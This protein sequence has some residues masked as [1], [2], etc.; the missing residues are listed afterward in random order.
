MHGLIHVIFKGFVVDTFGQ[1]A[2]QEIMRKA[3][4]EDDSTILKMQQYDDSLTFAAIQIGSEVAGAPMDAA[5]ELF[6]AYFVQFAA[7]NGFLSLLKSLGSNLAEFLSNLNILHH[8]IERDFTSAVFPLFEVQAASLPSAKGDHTFILRYG[9][10][11]PG[12]FPL[13]RGALKKTADLLFDAELE[14][15]ELAPTAADPAAL[16]WA[17]TTTPTEAQV[18][19]EMELTVRPRSVAQQASSQEPPRN[20]HGTFYHSSAHL[21]TTTPTPTTT[22]PSQN[23][24][25]SNNNNNNNNNN[26][27]YSY[28]FFDLHSALASIWACNSAACKD[29][30]QSSTQLEVVEAEPDWFSR[31]SA[32]LEVVE[33]EPNWFSKVAASC[34]EK[35]AAVDKVCAAYQNLDDA[36]HP[37]FKLSAKDRVKVGVSL[38]RGVVAGQIAA[39]WTDQTELAQATEF[40]AAYEKLDSFYA[41]SRDWLQPGVVGTFPRKEGKIRFLSQSWG[42][43]MGWDEMMGPNSSYSQAKAAEICC[44]AKD[45]ASRELGDVSRWREVGFWLDKCCIPQGDKVLMSWCVNLLEEFIVFSDGLIVLVP[46][47]Y[48]TRL[49]CVYEWVCFLLVHD[50]MDIEICADPF[51]RDSTMPLYISCISNFKLESCQC[52]HEPDR[53]ILL[54]KVDLYYK[55]RAAFERFLKFTSIALFARCAASRRSGKAAAALKP[56]SDLA[57]G[58]G[59]S[60][61]TG[62]LQ[63]M[64]ELLPGWRLEAVAGA[65]GGATHDVQSMV[66]RKVDDW[67]RAEMVPLILAERSQ[68]AAEKGLAYIKDLRGAAGLPH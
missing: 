37:Y 49:W 5:L 51:I 40:W 68:A 21:K 47:T 11:R 1:D 59:F 25:G 44:V 52:F 27:S 24:P 63:L 56:W 36:T 43:P 39:P 12:L 28:S 45:I 62:K 57:S 7:G 65:K 34:K 31:S 6:G 41:Q 17:R 10:S 35:H 20:D 22:P 18:S 42:L 32:H 4:V 33:P 38:F 46:W 13:L 2:W 26:N 67:F 23:S 61:L 3:G 15:R 16:P 48:F 54:A 53:A 66:A 19:M 9:S 60:E 29:S 8:N 64:A 58:S 50:P 14:I 30:T 55:S